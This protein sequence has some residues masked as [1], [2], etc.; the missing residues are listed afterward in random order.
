MTDSNSSTDTPPETVA[1][2]AGSLPEDLPPVQPP[3]AGYIIQLFLIPA[4]I[5]AA[6][7]GVWALFGKLADSETDWHQLV[8]ELGSSNEN[9]RWRAAL[10]L[11]QVLRNQQ[12]APD[13]DEVLL[14]RQPEV[15]VALSELL[16]ESMESRSTNDKEVKNQEF[17]ARTLGT[18]EADDIVL[19]MLAKA[20]ESDKN[21]EVRKSSLM[22]L[23]MI[24]GRKFEVQVQPDARADTADEIPTLDTPLAAPTINE[25]SVKQQLRLAAQDPEPAIRHLATFVLGLV[26][27]PEAVEQLE[28]LLLDGDSMTRAN[29]AVALARNGQ[30]QGVPVLLAMLTDGMTDPGRDDFAKLAPEQQQLLL[31]HRQFEQP[32]ILRNCIRAIQTLW[33]KIDEARQA[34]LKAILSQI[35]Q[36]HSAA[37]IRIQAHTL[38]NQI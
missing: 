34:E 30:V 16:K 3:S 36:E 18:L 27:G 12:L 37:D 25:E 6:V 14:A 22:S 11:A 23:A 10:G 19:P 32:I 24:A 21:I 5:V 26:S 4:L 33:P 7:I 9:R 15:A 28:V 35:S 20:L 38:L 17:L 29:A 1:F 31:Q 2:S 13:T 8:A